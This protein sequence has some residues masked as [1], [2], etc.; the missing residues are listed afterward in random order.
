MA[1]PATGAIITLEATPRHASNS[2]HAP[3]SRLAECEPASSAS[4]GVRSAAPRAARPPLPRPA[5]ADVAIVGAGYTGL[6]TAYYLKRAQTRRCGSL[7]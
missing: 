4:G 6:W 3:A 1:H 7:C 2:S 5:E